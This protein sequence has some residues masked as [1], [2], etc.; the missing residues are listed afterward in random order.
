[1][2]EEE[3]IFNV[4]VA[5]NTGLEPLTFTITMY[6][7]SSDPN[8]ERNYRVAR[9]NETLGVLHQ[10]ADDCWHYWKAIWN[11]KKSKR[12]DRQLTHIKPISSPH[13]QMFPHHDVRL[14]VNSY[15]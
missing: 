7:P 4:S 6:Y 5:I 14:P 11:R 12:S 15:F 3:E 13:L 1:M 8:H 9:D 2:Q 10:S